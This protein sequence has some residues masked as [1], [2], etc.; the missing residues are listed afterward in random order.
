MQR[1]LE[2]VLI[3]PEWEALMTAAA[4]QRLQPILEEMLRAYFREKLVQE[5]DTA[6]GEDSRQP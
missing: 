6:D 1:Q 4:R 3:C 5:T 2:L